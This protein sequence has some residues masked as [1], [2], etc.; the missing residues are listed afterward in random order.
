MPTKLRPILDLRAWR[1]KEDRQLALVIILFLVVVGGVT[2]GLVYGWG[3]ALTG[4]LGLLAGAG[5]FGL[6]WLMLSLIERWLRQE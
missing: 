3:V 5:I 1:R 6:L 2:I 4:A